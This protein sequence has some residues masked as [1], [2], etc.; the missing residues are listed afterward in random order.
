MNTVDNSSKVLIVKLSPYNALTSSNMRTIALIKGLQEMGYSIDW[1]TIA[2]SAVHTLRNMAEYDFMNKV[3]YI[4][5]NNFQVYDKIVTHKKGVKARLTNFLR[6]MYHAFSMYDY[7]QTIANKVNILSLSEK[8]YKYVFTISDPKSSHIALRRLKAQGLKFDKWIQ[9]WGDPLV[10]DITNKSV[11]PKFVL[12]HEE[13]KLF[14]SCDKIVYTSPFTLQNE[15][16]LHRQYKNK[17]IF[18]PTPF[19]EKKCY[20]KTNNRRPLVSYFG[21]YKSDIRNIVPLYDAALKVRDYFDFLI[22]GD[23]DLDLEGK[24]N[25]EIKPRGDVSEDEKCTDIYICVLNNS[26]TQIPG[27]V[28]HDAATDKPVLVILDGEAGNEIK[29][30]LSTFER[31]YFCANHADAIA[32]AL[33]YIVYENKNWEPSNQLEPVFVVN[34]MLHFK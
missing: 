17:M 14:A 25:I 26:G 15:A 1:L 6:K 13:R 21:S 18:V 9:Y 23:S 22:V 10:G 32:S 27:K 3:N 20:G 12:A 16:L 30:Y 2:P 11:Y 8:K 5:A 31:Y 7:T 33:R 34:K 29:E 19:I 4:F 28:Y 24:D